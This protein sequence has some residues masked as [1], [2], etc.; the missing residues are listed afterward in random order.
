MSEQAHKFKVGQTV[1]FVNDYGINWGE[2]T[3]TELIDNPV[4]GCTY[5]ITPTETPWFDCN[6]DNLF[7]PDDPAILTKTTYYAK[8]RFRTV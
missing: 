6:K 3:V 2:R 8:D 1:I 5:K 4:R 7:H